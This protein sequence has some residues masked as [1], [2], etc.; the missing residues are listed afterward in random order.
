M[1]YYHVSSQ[2][3][4]GYTIYPFQK[5]FSGWSKF[6]YDADFHN[7]LDVVKSYDHLM[8]S[9]VLCDTGRTPEK[10]LCEALFES[11][12]KQ[13]YPDCPTRIYGTFLCKELDDSRIFNQTKRKGSGTIFVVNVKDDVDFFNMQLFTDAESSL[14]QGLSETIY[15]KCIELAVEY[16]ESRNNGMISEKEYICMENLLLCEKIE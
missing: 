1:V 5:S 3:H 9:N 6:A 2:L 15:Q 16:W 7:Y 14:H 10:W 4:V 13:K 8:M 11:V 12:R